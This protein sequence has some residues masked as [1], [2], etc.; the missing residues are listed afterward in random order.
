MYIIYNTRL[1]KVFHTH[2]QYIDDSQ[3]AF[4][5]SNVSAV[6]DDRE[7]SSGAYFFLHT[8]FIDAN[9]FCTYWYSANSICVYFTECLLNIWAHRSWDCYGYIETDCCSG[10]QNTH[11]HTYSSAQK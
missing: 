3:I 1:I 6:T 9:E 5:V 10:I 4:I 7:T 11:K 2:T 8:F